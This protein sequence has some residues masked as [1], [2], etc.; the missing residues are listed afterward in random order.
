M[1]RKISVLL[2][3]A[4]PFSMAGNVFA[5][6]DVQDMLQGDWLFYGSD[7]VKLVMF[8]GDLFTFGDNKTNADNMYK[9]YEYQPNKIIATNVPDTGDD[10][11]FPLIIIDNNNI[12]LDGIS[13]H[14]QGSADNEN[15]LIAIAN[16][17]PPDVLNNQKYSRILLGYW[18]S[19]MGTNKAFI[20]FENGFI[21]NREYHLGATYTANRINSKEP[22]RSF[23]YEYFNDAT[24]K[25][26]G[27]TFTKELSLE[28]NSFYVEQWKHF[29]N[30]GGG[31]RVI[32]IE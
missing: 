16:G 3:I 5:D 23:R 30:S 24:I 4:V 12:L 21:Y 15:R 20:F 17:Y 7:L 8:R 18:K 10:I 14:R 26:D 11:E 29:H 19:V 9:W 13:Y 31:P 32:H 27:E 28:G 6:D 1:K 25:I 22:S 2:I